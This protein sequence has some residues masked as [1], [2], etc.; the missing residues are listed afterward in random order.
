MRARVREAGGDP[1]VLV[2]AVHGYAYYHRKS[3]ANGFDPTSHLTPETIFRPSN[4]P[5]Y[6][7]AMRD[8]EQ[9]GKKPPFRLGPE[10]DSERY[11]RIAREMEAEK[12]AESG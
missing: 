12:R 10:S 6:L 9:A 8:A 2:S 1:S 11:A 5:K 3:G 4:F 7:D